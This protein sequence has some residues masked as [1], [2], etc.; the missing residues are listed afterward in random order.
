MVVEIV[1]GSYPTPVERLDALSTPTCDLWVKRDDL[2]HPLYGGNKVRKLEHL[3]RDAKARGKTRIVTVGAVGSHHVLATTIFGARAGLSVEAMLVPQRTTD[4]VREVLRADL[5]QGLL[6]HRARTYVGA[7]LGMVARMGQRTYLIPMGGSTVVGSMGYFDAARELKKQ[8]DEGAMPEPDVAVVTVGS[9][10]T[11]AGLAAGFAALGMKTRVIGVVVATPPF[12][13]RWLTRWLMKRCF[14]GS[15]A[16]RVLFT[17]RYLG[18]GYG[19]PTEEGTR[20]T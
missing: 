13:V 9:G 7:A 11:A 6:A 17:S 2:T 1:H 15:S 8:I 18:A 12:A 10:G 3:L 20:A 19:E 16:D 14:A 5:S 4:H